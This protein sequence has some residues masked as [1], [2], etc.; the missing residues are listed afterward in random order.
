[1]KAIGTADNLIHKIYIPLA[2]TVREYGQEISHSHT[3]YQLTAPWGWATEHWHSQSIRKTIKV[4]D[5]CKT[6]NDKP[7]TAPQGL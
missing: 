7:I 1:M 2:P 3:A 4:E 6:R 5:D